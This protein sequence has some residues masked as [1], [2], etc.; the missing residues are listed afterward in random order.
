MP[1]ISGMGREIEIQRPQDFAGANNSIDKGETEQQ[2]VMILK[3]F[4]CL[5]KV[6]VYILGF[7]ISIWVKKMT[8]SCLM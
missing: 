4:F 8:Q 1:Q 3:H 7:L 5:Y 6:F 2:K